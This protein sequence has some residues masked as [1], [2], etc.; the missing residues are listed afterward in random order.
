[1]SVKIVDTLGTNELKIDPSHGA[2]RASIRPDEALTWLSVGATSGLLTGVAA[3]GTLFSLRNIG[4]NLLLVRRI[5]I[6]FITTTAFTAAQ[7]LAFNAFVARGFSAS[8]SGGTQIVLTGS[9]NK[10]RTSLPAPTNLDCRIATTA[11]LTAG[12]RTLDTVALGV[13]GGASTGVGTAMSPQNLLQHDAG[14][15][16]LVLANNE[17]LILANS[18][19]MGA[20]GV[21]N[22]HVNIEFAEMTAF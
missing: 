9:Q 2:A 18:L 1:M 22:L 11:A 3:G 17:G 19:A 6:G 12:T 5:S 10:L 4:T 21:I 14:D 20:A 7:G 16:P 15:Y 13:A 8:D